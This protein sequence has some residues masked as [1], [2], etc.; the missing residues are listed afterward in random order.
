MV[1]AQEMSWSHPEAKSNFRVQVREPSTTGTMTSPQA[2]ALGPASGDVA[3][4]S[5]SGGLGVALL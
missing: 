5:V 2:A 1:V 4:L 3:G